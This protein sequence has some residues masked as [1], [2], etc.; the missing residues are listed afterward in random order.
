M[1]TAEQASDIFQAECIPGE[2]AIHLFAWWSEGPG[3]MVLTDLHAFR[4]LLKSMT[5]QKIKCNGGSTFRSSDLELS[6]QQGEK[7]G[8]KQ[9]E[10]A[11]HWSKRIPLAYNLLLQEKADAQTESNS[12]ETSKRGRY[13]VPEMMW[14]KNWSLGDQTFYR[15]HAE[16]KRATAYDK[17]IRD[18]TSKWPYW[19]ETSGSVSHPGLCTR[20]TAIASWS[21]TLP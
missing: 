16:L 19:R 17:Q 2:W 12:T 21:D 9:F 14:R 11:Q 4:W 10:L 7:S 1:G 5:W 3:S 15:F 6:I 20:W 18:W 13:I 8:Y